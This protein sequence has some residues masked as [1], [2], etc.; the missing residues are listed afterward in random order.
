MP[1]PDVE[2]ERKYLLRALPNLP[3]GT[4]SVE[5]EQGWIPGTRI[6]ERLR[7]T[8]GPTGVHHFRT[9]KFGTG[10]RRVEVEEEISAE[11]FARMWPLTEG[12]R[13]AK[14]R[15]CVPHGALR[16]EIDE[17]A[18]RDLVLAEIEL[19]AVD[20]PVVVPPWLASV[21]VREVTGDPAYVNAN[22][23]TRA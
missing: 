1:E 11:L 15:H 4:T 8:R 13:I 18:G 12:R 20:T 17:F 16:W 5:I 3:A 19:P 10:I 21:M 6:L 23:A 22:L 7:R 2:I 14:R 9:I